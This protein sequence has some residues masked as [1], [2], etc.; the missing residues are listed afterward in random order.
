MDYGNRLGTVGI[1]VACILAMSA[2]ASAVD[3]VV[4]TTPDEAIDVD[5]G[6]LPLNDEDSENLGDALRG[7]DGSGSSGS[8]GN[9]Q[10]S[11]GGADRG[12]EADAAGD[13]SESATGNTRDRQDSSAADRSDT[14]PKQANG[15]ADSSNQKSN[16]QQPTLLERLLNL[17]WDLLAALLGALPW[18]GLLAALGL[19]V[20]YRD[21][22]LAH[23]RPYVPDRPGHEHAETGEPAPQHGIEEAW[24]E[25][26]HAIDSARDPTVTPSD[27]A[28]EAIESGYDAEAVRRLT[29]IY[30]EVRYGNATA[31]PERERSAR[32][33]AE[34]LRDGE[35]T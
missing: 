31:T 5:P 30:E 2:A 12:E 33:I 23:L 21:R 16:A 22:I 1:A 4:T 20:A 6:S 29:T 25:L 11:E 3:S 27:C 18:L 24:A 13:R 7:E 35:R 15:G 10:V 19:A 8:E 14:Q 26:L 32:N 9:R 34:R 17:V 28:E